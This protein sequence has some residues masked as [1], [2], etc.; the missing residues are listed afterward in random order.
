MSAMGLLRPAKPTSVFVP[1]GW[2]SAMAVTSGDFA[3]LDNGSDTMVLFLIDKL[4]PLFRSHRKEALE[5]FEAYYFSMTPTIQMD[6]AETLLLGCGMKRGLL[7]QC[8][9][10]SW[11]TF[12]LKRAA[13]KALGLLARLLDSAQNAKNHVFVSV[14]LQ[15]APSLYRQLKLHRHFSSS[16]R[17]ANKQAALF[18]HCFLSEFRQIDLSMPGTSEKEEWCNNPALN[19][20]RLNHR[21]SLRSTEADLVRRGVLKRPIDHGK[22]SSSSSPSRRSIAQFLVRLLKLRPTRDVLLKEGILKEG[23]V[24]GCTMAQLARNGQ[25]GADGVP[26]L[27]RTCCDHLRNTH[28]LQRVKG[29]FRVSAPCSE[30]SLLRNEIDFDGALESISRASSHSVYILACVHPPPHLPRHTVQTIYETQPY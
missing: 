16:G 19:I 26:L 18:V 7:H 1:V 25:L 20:S 28:A 5:H 24:F 11:K 9:S 4:Q 3:E 21:I 12:Q 15:L 10:T 8:G 27:V 29:L 13:G 30:M 23:K 2:H 22:S 17:G 6:T 14:F